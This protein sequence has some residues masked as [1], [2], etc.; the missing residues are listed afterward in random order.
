MANGTLTTAMIFVW[1]LNVM[2]I[3]S[4]LAV[5]DMTENGMQFINSSGTILKGYS[6][7]GCTNI[8]GPSADDLTAQ[9]PTGASETGG[10]FIVDWITSA[11]S[12]IGK[13]KDTFIQVVSAPTT[14]LKTIPLFQLAQYSAFAA[15]IGVMWWGISLLLI[16]AFIFGR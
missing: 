1:I 11:T 8:A 7:D 5:T 2:M 10:F 14:M 6:T 3:F 13:Q 9:L 12:W 16:V 4:Q 15:I